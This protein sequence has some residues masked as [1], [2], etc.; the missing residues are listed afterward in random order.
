MS[1]PPDL[2][3]IVFVTR[4]F[5]ELQGLQSVTLGTVLIAGVLSW[6]LLPEEI[7]DPFQHIAFPAAMY[8]VGLTVWIALYYRRWFGRVPPMTAR[9]GPGSVDAREILHVSPLFVGFAADM[10]K[11]LVYPGGPS[12]AAAGLAV[13]SLWIL[14]R[15]GLHRPHYVIGL[16]AGILGVS[17][18]WAAPFSFRVGRS[19]DPA[20]AVPYVLTYAVMGAAQASDVVYN[21]LARGAKDRPQDQLD[22]LREKVKQDY[23]EQA[24]IRY[25]AARGWVDAII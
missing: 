9:P 3:R 18:T 2:A 22:A 8:P 19:L 4:R 21:I 12:L 13:Y 17:A 10:V 5:G 14:V 1:M 16:A 15:D 20:V 7:R 6:S 23:V 24:D 11:A 25:G